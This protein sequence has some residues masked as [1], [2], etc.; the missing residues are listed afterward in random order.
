MATEKITQVMSEDVDNNQIAVKSKCNASTTAG[1]KSDALKVK[2]VGLTA[3]HND[4]HLT[5]TGGGSNIKFGDVVR[6]QN[7]GPGIDNPSIRS[8]SFIRNT[9]CDSRDEMLM[10]VSANRQVPNKQRIAVSTEAAQQTTPTFQSEVLPN[11]RDCEEKKHHQLEQTSIQSAQ[12][13]GGFACISSKL[14]F[15]LKRYY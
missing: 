1:C 2:V 10:D 12:Y 9:T 13:C 15:Y 6:R 3:S 5:E 7:R 14:F 11:N 8:T 4:G